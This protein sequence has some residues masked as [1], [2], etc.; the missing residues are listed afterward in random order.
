[1]TK[2]ILISSRGTDPIECYVLEY[3]PSGLYVKL[4]NLYGNL[5]WK[6]VTD[7]HIIEELPEDLNGRRAVAPE[8]TP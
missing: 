8:T 5:F 1:M 7:V 3:S 2:R 6:R 4:S